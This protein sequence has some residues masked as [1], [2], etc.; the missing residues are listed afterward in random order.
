MNKHKETAARVTLE[1]S[2]F[3]L[4]DASA[5]VEFA[6]KEAEMDTWQRAIDIIQNQQG[7][8]HW[9]DDDTI[10]LFREEMKKL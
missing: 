7:V 2:V 10:E 5:I 3:G 9:T 6:L 1:L 4:I 8:S